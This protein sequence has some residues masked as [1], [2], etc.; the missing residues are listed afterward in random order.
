[1]KNIFIILSIIFSIVVFQNCKKDSSEDVG[2]DQS[3]MGEVGNT[4]SM[5][6]L[7]GI[8]N[9]TGS[10]TELKD[11]V[12]NVY[13]TGK[14]VNDEFK[15]LAATIPSFKFGSYDPN[16]GNFNGNLKMKFTKEGI[17]DYL[18]VAE[19]PFT[20]ARF[21]AKVGDTY[22]CEKANGGTF[23]RTVTAKSDVDDFPYGFMDIKTI[24]VEESGRNPAISK[25]VYRLNHKFGLVHAKVVLQDGSEI[26]SYLYSMAEN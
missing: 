22:T 19:R 8:T 18:N 11:G 2:G 3:T 10:V 26:S 15:Q 25:I 20:L 23:T 14:I 24:T 4:F 21:D 13:V 6:T 7:P 5:S 16:T 9:V 17:V 12:S 1:M